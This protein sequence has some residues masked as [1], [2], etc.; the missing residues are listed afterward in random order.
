MIYTNQT[1]YIYTRKEGYIPA[2][3]KQCDG[4]DVIVEGYPRKTIDEAREGIRAM[5]VLT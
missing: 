5:E 4:R 2:I 1:K 3:K